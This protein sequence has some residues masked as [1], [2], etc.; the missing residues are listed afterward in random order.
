MSSR[1]WFPAFVVLFIC[2]QAPQVLGS[3]L[4]ML[5]FL[6]VAWLVAR[7]L[8]LGM[9]AAYAL[10]WSPRTAW[11]LAGGFLLALL[12]KLGAL[13]IGTRLG[14][15]AAVEA[16]PPWQEILRAIAWTSLY[17]FVPSLA[18][19]ILTRG[20]WARVPAW[21]W[22]AWGFVLFSSVIYVLN[23]LHRLANGPTEWLMLF[24]F[25]LA[26]ATAL[27][28]TGSL[29]AAV[30]LHWGWNFS[31][32]FLGAWWNNTLPGGGWWLS[33][34]AH[35]LLAAACLLVL[36]PAADASAP[37]GRAPADGS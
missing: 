19:D 10:E 9:S 18:E 2:Y 21:R 27:W 16:D 3:P 28:R 20:F 35:L 6:P 23:H 34:G 17:T 11:I 26:Y 12:T 14:I 22:T 33:A 32:S 4:L 1:Y 15:Y 13:L 5:V 29:W 30:G 8:K 36:S 31:G 25:G 37:R 24:C 7:T